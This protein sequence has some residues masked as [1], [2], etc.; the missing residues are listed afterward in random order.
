M[1]GT[2]INTIAVLIG[3]SIGLLVGN[4]LTSKMQETVMTG[5]GFVSVAIA[6]QNMQVTGNILIPLFSLCIGAIIGELLDLDGALKR[7]GGWLQERTG[8][9]A[10]TDSE[11]AAIKARIRFINAFV[12]STL[13]FCVGPLTIL[14]SIQNG[15]DNANVQLLVVKSTLDFFASIA[16]A[17]TLGVG[18]VFSA[19]AVLVIQGS[20]A[21]FGAGMAGLLTA[22][23]PL[24]SSN[25][26][27]KELTAT[28]GLIL[29]GL[30][31]ILMNIKQ[32]RVANY[33][34]AL[35]IAPL[36]VGLG[37][38]LGINLYPFG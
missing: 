35:L 33:L 8:A 32:P 13:V 14:G 17:A 12:T 16:F 24:T 25:P 11:D 18:V 22:G 26:Y 34:P 5:L 10:E 15:M 27:I 4:R 9:G 20:L 37:K 38:L 23:G 3:S 36:L 31:L 29:V 28:G 1:S 7:L 6:I 30:S 19:L 2:L 21:L